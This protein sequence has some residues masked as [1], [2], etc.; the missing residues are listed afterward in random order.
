L[1]SA[2]GY[3]WLFDLSRNPAETL[4]RGKPIMFRHGAEG[5]PSIDPHGNDIA[6]NTV[7]VVDV[8]QAVKLPLEKLKKITK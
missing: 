3:Y 2:E 6:P 1:S 8:I 5:A 7:A 4:D